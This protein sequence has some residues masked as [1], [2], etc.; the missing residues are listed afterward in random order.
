MG[1]KHHSPQQPKLKK[2][3]KKNKSISF[4]SGK[5]DWKQVDHTGNSMF[6][7]GTS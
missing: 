6:S 3:K 5:D 1:I 2:K 7:V 4:I